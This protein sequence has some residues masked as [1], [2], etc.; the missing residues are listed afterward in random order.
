[1]STR[2]RLPLISL[3]AFV[4]LFACAKVATAQH[5]PAAG[6]GT[7]GGGST[8]RPSSSKPATKPQRTKPQ[9][10]HDRAARR[11]HRPRHQPDDTSN[12]RRH[13]ASNNSSQPRN[14]KQR[15]SRQLLPTRRST[16]TKHRNTQKLSIYYLRAAQTQ[17][18]NGRRALS[19]RLDPKR[20]RRLRRCHR[21]S[22][23][24]H[25]CCNPTTQPPT[26]NSAMHTRNSNA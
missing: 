26:S 19:H 15:S 4:C 9:E 24:S 25:R 10:R 16:L 2:C 8:G 3:T 1:M 11:E 7:I 17:P 14:C 22:E 18:V 20:S 12:N 23:A 6:G 21:S 5:E 13:H